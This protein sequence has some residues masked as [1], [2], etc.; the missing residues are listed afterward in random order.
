MILVLLMS[1]SAVAMAESVPSKTVL[2]MTQ[3]EV[4]AENQPDDANIFLLPVNE[5]TVGEALP[6]YQEYI[7][8]CTLEI[9]K[10]AASENVESYFGE[11]VDAEGN[12]VDLRALL[13]VEDDV[14]L[15]VFE[16]C[17]AIAGGF[18]EE[19]GKVTAKLLFST[20]YEKDE[21]VLVLIGVVT[22]LDETAEPTAEPTEVPETEIDVLADETQS[23]KWHV[24][25]G[26]GMDM[27][28][29]QEETYGSI[30]VELTQE[31][32]NSIQ[33]EMALMAVVSK[34]AT[35]PVEDA[36]AENTVTE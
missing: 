34:P 35:E 33:N 24:F 22:K 2:A 5:A 18:Q 4:V 15:D 27:V 11:V 7:D 31:I 30:Q 36:T 3:F 6:Q 32:V 19:C 23:V 26:V 12:V 17:P 28:E 20:P 21:K 29:D 8:A 16:F 25:E 10:M 9:E 14:A 13:E 1:V